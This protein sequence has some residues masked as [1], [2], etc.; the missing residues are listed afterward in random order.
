[1]GRKECD[2]GVTDSNADDEAIRKLLDPDSR[3]AVIRRLLKRV[4]ERMREDRTVY[5]KW[6]AATAKLKA[7]E[8]PDTS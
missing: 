5:T 6:F 8:A 2:Y 1:M 3:H 4:P 7:R